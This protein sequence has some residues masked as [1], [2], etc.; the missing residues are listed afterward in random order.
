MEHLLKDGGDLDSMDRSLLDYGQNKVL[1]NQQQQNGGHSTSAGQ[2]SGGGSAS[3][4]TGL[5][6]NRSVPR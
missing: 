6:A 4:A 5:D 3:T 1:L 2:H